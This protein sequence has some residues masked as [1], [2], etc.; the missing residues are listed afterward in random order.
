MIQYIKP[1]GRRNANR[2]NSGARHTV[3]D[4]L[5]T[6]REI[7]ELVGRSASFTRRHIVENHMNPDKFV[8]KYKGTK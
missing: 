1:R 2:M 3:G 5:L 8:E 6:I 4:Q 7:A